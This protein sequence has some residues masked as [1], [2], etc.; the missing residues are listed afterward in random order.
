MKK[1]GQALSN[2]RLTK[3]NKFELIGF[4]ACLMGSIEVANVLRPF[5][6]YMVASEETEPGYGWDYKFLA[7]TNRGT[8]T[9]SMGRSIVDSFMEHYKDSSE[10][11]LSLALIKL[12]PLDDVMSAT[13]ELFGKLNEEVTAQTFSSFSVA[14]TRKKV[15]GYSGRD[16][17]S[18]DLVDLK[19]L[20]ESV[21]NIYPNEVKAVGD[22]LAKVVLYSRNNIEY[23]NGLSVYFPTNNRENVAQLL[24]KYSD[25][26]FSD[27]YYNFLKRYGGFMSGEP[28][29]KSTNFQDVPVKSTKDTKGVTATLPDE[30]ADNYQSAEII[31]MR[32]IGENK[33]VPVYRSS[34]VTKEG[35]TIRS[36]SMHLQF[37]AEVTESDGKKMY[38]WVTTFEKERTNEYADYVIFGLA[39][40]EA[41]D[42][43]LGFTPKAY[44]MNIRLPKDKKT[45]EI[46]N[47]R[48]QT[49]D[50]NLVSKEN[51]DI[52]KI[53]FIEMVVPSYTEDMQSLGVMYGTSASFAKK[54]KLK[55]KLVDLDFDFGDMY[56]GEISRDALKDYYARFVIHDTQGK[57]HMLKLFHIE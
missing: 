13:G 8:D 9:E 43:I 24:A 5:A 7:K 31:I 32:K 2:S 25:V 37:V 40:Y 20:S 55:F 36:N 29:V 33:F 47:I 51:L 10:Y 42:S 6:D 27:K 11:D 52:K 19:D 26:S 45:A 3:Q 53:Q 14:L 22:A 49:G 12:G 15:Y 56:E 18:M 35:N 41:K 4:D 28:I 23:T 38:G 44:E 50:D 57:A 48:T 1:M 54:E 39:G 30:L 34:E 16:N 21:T 17:S 46:R